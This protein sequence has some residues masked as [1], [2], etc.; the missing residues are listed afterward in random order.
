MQI[1]HAF[2]NRRSPFSLF[3][4]V[5]RDFHRFVS[6]TKPPLFFVDKNFKTLDSSTI[7]PITCSPSRI[8]VRFDPRIQ[9]WGLMLAVIK[10]E[11]TMPTPFNFYLLTSAPTYGILPGSKSYLLFLYLLHFFHFT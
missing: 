5:T 2:E 10:T 7:V 3:Y 8:V 9:S 6:S 1:P 11:Y 4:S